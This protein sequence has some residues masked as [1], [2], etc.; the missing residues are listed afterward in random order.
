MRITILRHYKISS[1]WYN[2]GIN[3]L[4]LHQLNLWV[5][6]DYN[7]VELEYCTRV[8]FNEEKWFKIGNLYHCNCLLRTFGLQRVSCQ[9]YYLMK[10][11]GF[12]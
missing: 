10:R 1:H 11:N 6:K 4:R 7:I 9:E 12:K 8:L 2:N 3:K 5:T